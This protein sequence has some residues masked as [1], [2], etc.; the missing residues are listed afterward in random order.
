MQ[1]VCCN[2]K[3]RYQNA[4]ASVLACDI[5]KICA[6]LKIKIK[7]GEFYMTKAGERIHAMDELRG[8]AIICMVF[9]HAFYTMSFMFDISAGSVLF[10]FFA[11]AQ[12][13]FA[14]GFIVI[15]GIASCLSRSNLKRGLCL[16]AVALG[17]TVVTCLFL[18]GNE[19]YFGILHLLAVCMV[20]A[21]FVMPVLEKIPVA[22]GAG[23]NAVLF[24]MTYDVMYGR[25]KIPF[26]G[27]VRLPSSLYEGNLLSP[28]GFFNGDYF[29]ADYFPI[30]PYMFMFFV[31]VFVGRLA[32]QGRFPLFLYKSR[33][34]FLSFVGRHTLII[35]IV[36][37]PI[38]YVIL[39][40]YAYISG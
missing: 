20:A 25:L 15:S 13:Y 2:A 34:P 36:H 10:S 37:Q 17:V 12:V 14:C 38:I 3:L 29:S 11:P 26:Y 35:Y 9:F 31:G 27:Y 4:L 30:L 21:H 33:V 24:Y 8:F 28:L 23:V 19:I 22:I 32:K 18:K 40:L 39:S 6:R 5:I 1:W 16:F 7:D